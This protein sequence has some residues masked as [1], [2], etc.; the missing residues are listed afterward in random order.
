MS[1][2]LGYNSD[3]KGFVDSQDEL[4]IQ[5]NKKKKGIIAI[6]IGIIL[7]LLFIFFTFLSKSGVIDLLNIFKSDKSVA[8]A[9]VIDYSSQ[10]TYTSNDNRIVKWYC[11]ENKKNKDYDTYMDLYKEDDYIKV[12]P[13]VGVWTSGT[14]VVQPTSRIFYVTEKN[15]NGITTGQFVPEVDNL[16]YKENEIEYHRIVFNDDLS[17]KVGI[18]K[19]NKGVVYQHIVPREPEDIVEETPVIKV[20]EPMS[21]VETP[22][23]NIINTI[24]DPDIPV[25]PRNDPDPD[26]DDEEKDPVKPPVVIPTPTPIPPQPQPDPVPPRPTPDPDPKPKTEEGRYV[27]EHI[28][29]SLDGSYGNDS[30]LIQKE[31]GKG[32]VGTR[33]PA[34]AK[35]YTGFTDQD[36]SDAN[37]SKNTTTKVVIKYKR[38]SYSITY[39]N[40]NG[41]DR[42]TKSYLY[43]ETVTNPSTPRK[44]GYVFNSWIY[45]TKD[46]T[47]ISKPSKM[48]AQGLY[49]EASWDVEPVKTASYTIKHVRQSLDGTYGNDNTLIETVTKTGTVG[50][51]TVGEQ[52]TYTGFEAQPYTNVA[53]KADN[54]TVLEIHYKRNNY[55]IAYEISGTKQ[56]LYQEAVVP[57]SNPSK[58]H[59]EFVK[60]IYKDS[61]GI[62]IDKPT[63][64]PAENL[65]AEAVWI[66]EIVT[67]TVK[68]VRQN[69]DGTYG[70]DDSLVETETFNNSRYG[71]SVTPVAK[72]YDGFSVVE[73]RST[74][75]AE[76]T[77]IEVYYMRNSYN[78]TYYDADG[79]TFK[80]TVVVYGG[81]ITEPTET[82]EKDG[83]IFT[84]WYYVGEEGGNKPATMPYH[85]LV[86]QPQWT[87]ADFTIKYY[88]DSIGGTLY[89]TKTVRYSN[90]IEVPASNPS[91]TGHTFSFWQYY[92]ESD[93]SEITTP[94]KMP[95]YNLVAVA[96]Y[97]ADPVNYTIKHIRQNIDGTYG[98]DDNLIEIVPGTGSYGQ[99]ITLEPNTYAGFTASSSNPTSVELGYDTE[100]ELKYVRDSY[101]IYYR[102]ADNSYDKHVDIK[103]GATLDSL[104]TYFPD[105]PSKTGFTNNVTNYVNISGEDVGTPAT[106]PLYDLYYIPI[107]EENTY[108]INYHVNGGVGTDFSVNYKYTDTVIL[109]YIGISDEQGS[110]G[111]YKDGYFAG[112]LPDGIYGN[113]QWNTEANGG[114]TYYRN[115][116][117]ITSITSVNND[118]IDLYVQWA[119]KRICVQ[120]QGKGTLTEIFN[121]DTNGSTVIAD[122]RNQYPAPTG[123][124]FDIWNTEADGSGLDIA[125][126]ATYQEIQGLWEQIN[127]TSLRTIQHTELV[128]TLYPQYK[129]NTYNIVYH[130]NNGKDP[131]ST[132]TETVSYN[133]V[134]NLRTLEDILNDT[135]GENWVKFGNYVPGYATHNHVFWSRNA[136]GTGTTYDNGAEV[137]QL[138]PVDN[139]NID[140]YIVW[141]PQKIYVYF[142]GDG[143]YSG[144]REIFTY[145]DNVSGQIGDHS[146]LL[147]KAGQKFNGQYTTVKQQ[148]SEYSEAPKVPANATYKYIQDNLAD[149]IDLNYIVIDPSAGT[150]TIP[151]LNSIRQEDVQTKDLYPDYEPIQYTIKFHANGGTGTKA[152]RIRKY[153]QS[154]YGWLC[155]ESF[156]STYDPEG[157]FIKDGY[158]IKEWNTAQDG[159][160]T[161]YTWRKDNNLTTVDGAVVDLYAIWEK[162]TYKIVLER[163]N[164][165]TDT[166]KQEINT[167]WGESNVLSSDAFSKEGYNF[168]KWK[169]NWFGEGD[170]YN[171][172]SYY[173]TDDFGLEIKYNAGKYPEVYK[174]TISNVTNIVFDAQWLP[175]TYTV[176]FDI[177]GGTGTLEPVEH[178]Y[179]AGKVIDT[180]PLSRTGYTLT[181][182]NTQPDGSGKSC[183]IFKYNGK[184][185]FNIY[186]LTTVDGDIVTL[187]AQWEPITYNIA[188][189][190][191]GGTATTTPTPIEA[192]YDTSY[193]LASKDDLG[194]TNDELIFVG[195]N[196]E[197]D[198]SGTPYTDADTVKNLTSTQDETVTLY[199]QWVEGYKVNYYCADLDVTGTMETSVFIPGEAG[200]LT[201]NAFEKTGYTFDHWRGLGS[202]EYADEASWTTI[203]FYGGHE[204]NLEPV[205]REH[206]YT[207]TLKANDGTG[208][209]VVNT[210]RYSENIDLQ[211]PDLVGFAKPGYCFYSSSTQYNTAADGSGT[212]YGSGSGFINKLT[213]EDNGEITLYVQWVPKKVK[214]SFSRGTSTG[215]MTPCEYYVG[216]TG[217]I[218]AC[219]FTKTG[220]YEF[221]GWYRNST[222][223]GDPIADQASYSD[224]DVTTVSNYED[225]SVY[226]NDT[227]SGYPTLKVTLYSKWEGVVNLVANYPEGTSGTA[228]VSSTD[229]MTVTDT[230]IKIDVDAGSTVTIPAKPF[231]LD[232]YVFKGWNT[233]SDG[234]GTKGGETCSYTG[235]VITQYNGTLYA[236]WAIP[237]TYINDKY[238]NSVGTALGIT[239]GTDIKHINMR[240]PAPAEGVA[241]YDCTANVQYEGKADY[242]IVMWFDSSTETL[243][244]YTE[245]TN[246]Y[247]TTIGNIYYVNGYFSY[248]T[249]LQDIS[250]L[251][252]VS[253]KYATDIGG[254]FYGDTSITAEE[255]VNLIN[256]LDTTLIVDMNRMFQGCTGINGDI[257]LTDLNLPNCK[258][259]GGMFR[260]ASVD[261]FYMSGGTFTKLNSVSALLYQSGVTEVTITNVDFPALTKM[262]NMCARC[263]SLIS[264]SITD[265][266]TPA[267][268][269]LSMMFNSIPVNENTSAIN[270]TTCDL[271][272]L[273]TENV[274]TMYSMFSN[275]WALTD[276]DISTWN[277]S[278]L[279]NMEDMFYECKSLETLDLSSFNTS[280]LT[281][282]S[283]TF[284]LC[285]KL[286]TVYVSDN[287]DISGVSDAETFGSNK[288]VGGFGFSY[289]SNPDSGK[290]SSVYA[291]ANT[292]TVDGYFTG[293]TSAII[294]N[295]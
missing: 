34:S 239:P 7:L 41:S 114:G 206:T 208:D 177:N 164:L 249:S 105:A 227:F 116:Q 193:T 204:I 140:L 282:L 155:T 76:N 124:T 278:S 117:N 6:I 201:A 70:G 83:Y 71:D 139:E 137:S 102:D 154:D 171:N 101:R 254:M 162:I 265:V 241:T 228:T 186:N 267:L 240:G 292:E 119:P 128:L 4:D 56:Y 47:V 77:V 275:C 198:G 245:A 33:V 184:K 26:D 53:I 166:Q 37:I 280:N 69:V 43:E 271:T 45:K 238:P 236:Q 232:G 3:Q 125:Y 205:F 225:Y 269:D 197:M 176:N 51:L 181:S 165:N 135:G 28:R 50:D 182:F 145:D 15:S 200:T 84:G 38:N 256:S 262:D 285:Y 169:M 151:E 196:T 64:M 234:S 252:K 272:G 281:N 259:M 49:C 10:E 113:H 75:L 123:Y 270:M 203:N 136:D 106:M 222:F 63:T 35:S 156:V 143:V 48:P 178:K 294:Y 90:D 19:K 289:V 274:T 40:K 79:N 229:I 129:E 65:T 32:K 223:T 257:S 188:L 112:C 58:P 218:P 277:T 195:W 148:Y 255:A 2:K 250:N 130:A 82:P 211:R 246:V 12:F 100:V 279:K 183:V 138:T 157:L 207:V 174:G 226:A 9:N 276:L 120:F 13:I 133:E 24:K 46:G 104:T 263:R 190:L 30:S 146:N 235:S 91:K 179:D 168:D 189:D 109:P 17:V 192:K 149:L 67:Y 87:T 152:D 92:K 23:M 111:W 210:Y 115:G 52:N 264:V 144:A 221:R 172:T 21:I 108:T 110:L 62:V 173:T 107:W 247:F 93:S 283:W 163:S 66:G 122:N 57:A 213:A 132:Y 25:I 97:D 98:G 27:I 237:V 209:D 243:N 217:N 167:T 180:A 233:A 215:S 185:V 248:L 260:E 216:D 59:S 86:A 214:I 202:D 18:L 36:Y 127:L 42:Y 39:D 103:Q 251:D 29:Q 266:N 80:Q 147:N 153:G 244:Y 291:V 212:P 73:P 68:H 159:S 74:T 253:I 161:G 78:V 131:E 284:K 89:D 231:T 134:H 230:L 1:D 199:A 72:T 11:R 60:W 94:A 286:K 258:D 220:S 273:D 8:Y 288:L 194:L 219:T 14:S 44:E 224:I 55:N 170:Y 95:A 242:P 142:Y 287:W 61:N 141:K 31:S 261:K 5:Q 160:G 96:Q 99:S 20:P 16:H 268:K 118:V 54:S 295:P 290:N 22:S 150:I 293:K 81:T 85:P 187:Y 175:I 126:N 158:R 121:Y 191:N 88:S